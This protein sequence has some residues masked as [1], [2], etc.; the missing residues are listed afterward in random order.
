MK[1]FEKLQ[2]A[3]CSRIWVRQRFRGRKPVFCPVCQ[4]QNVSSAATSVSKQ[5]PAAL[6]K[7]DLLQDCFDQK[8]Q[9]E[10][11]VYRS[12]YPRNEDI[13]EVTKKL[14]VTTWTCQH[15]SETLEVEVPLLDIPVHKCAKHT[16]E[17][18]EYTLVR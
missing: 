5:G 1:V 15:C 14:G 13:Y 17:M 7:E 12:Y 2:C 11:K 6:V 9:I 3:N 18:V 16:S 8:R 10:G 4:R